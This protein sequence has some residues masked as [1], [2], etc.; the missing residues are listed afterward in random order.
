VGFARSLDVD[1]RDYLPFDTPG[2][3]RTAL[4]ALAP[5]ALVFSKLDVWPVITR[6]ARARGVK[7]G[8]ISATVSRGSSRRSRAATNLLR[9]AYASL[10]AVGAVDDADADRLV[11]LGV[12]PRVI[13][14]TGD[15]RYDQV[16]LRAQRV[17]RASPM[18]E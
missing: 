1:F 8:L 6:A 14:I 4:D 13:S 11:Q 3:A 16:W 9:D 12:R 5:T 17:D 2:D 7:L 18:L 10:D 15:T